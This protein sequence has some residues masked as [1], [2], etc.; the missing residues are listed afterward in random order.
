GK[1]TA[2]ARRW[3]V[4]NS[5]CEPTQAA[6][7]SRA[8]AASAAS[9]TIMPAKPIDATCA[10]RSM[11]RSFRSTQ[12]HRWEI[13]CLHRWLPAAATQQLRGAAAGAR[14]VEWPLRAEPAATPPPSLDGGTERGG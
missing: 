3:P 4:V 7:P 9:N 5:P 10:A 12:E 8:P 1:P 2:V 14:V 6:S 11:G 13:G